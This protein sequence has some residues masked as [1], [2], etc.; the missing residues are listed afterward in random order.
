[1]FLWGA[2]KEQCVTL[3]KGGLLNVLMGW[4]Y[5]TVCY[6][7]K[8]GLLK[9]NVLLWNSVLSLRCALMG[10]SDDIIIIVTG[11]SP[12]KIQAFLVDCL[13]WALCVDQS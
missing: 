10:C 9:F 7:I 4:F 6:P 13:K 8:G 5:G 11:G 12:L 1:M 3:I 2:F